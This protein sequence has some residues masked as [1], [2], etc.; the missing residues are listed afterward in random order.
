MNRTKYYPK[1]MYIAFPAIAMMLGWGLRGHIGGG[2]FGAMIPGAMVALCVGLLLEMPATAASF[3]L[4]FGVIG[5]GLGGEMTYGQTLGF[6][7]DPATVWWGT[8][9]TTLKGAVWGLLGG[10]V[11]ALGFFFRSVPRKIL[12][13][14]FLLMILGIIVGFK[15]INDPMLLYFSDPVK[16]RPESWAGLLLGALLFMGYLKLKIPAENFKIILRYAIWGTIG[17]AL[18]FGLGG[19]W[20]VLGSHLPEVIFGSWW[21]AMEFTFG[22]LL[23]A[24]LGYATWLSRN[25]LVF[26]PDSKEVGEG[27][28]LSRWKELLVGLGTGLLIF[29]LLPA[30]IEVLGKVTLDNNM[31]GG[32]LKNEVIRFVDNYSLT[33]LIF[34]L[35][36]LRFPKAAWQIGITLTFCHTAID[37]FRDFYP[38]ANRLSPFTMYFFWVLLTTAVVAIRAAYSENKKGVIRSML[39]LVTWSCVAVSCIRMFIHPELFDV[40]GLSFCEVVCGRFFVDLFFVVSAIVTSWMTRSGFKIQAGAIK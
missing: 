3:L 22:L 21:K 5:I 8:A 26:E 17:G 24:S 4:V 19:F 27:N 34:V 25:D 30:L 7:K 29:W 37:L 9:G 32:S 18:G 16:P 13:L 11:F 20:L 36:L 14:S 2:P 10:A 39:L 12:I 33:G 28:I 15:L 23:G 35:V 1:W 31:P 38:D 40:T 6:L